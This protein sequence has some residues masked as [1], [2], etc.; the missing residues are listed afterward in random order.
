MEILINILIVAAWGFLGIGII[1]TIS[2]FVLYNKYEGSLEQALDKV[3]GEY[4]DFMKLARIGISIIIAS[5]I[6]LIGY[7]T[8]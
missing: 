5:A 6:V 1:L 4:Q 8:V 3:S 2:G 7:Y